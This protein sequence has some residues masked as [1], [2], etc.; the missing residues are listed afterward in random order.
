MSSL[1]LMYPTASSCKSATSH[2]AKRTQMITDGADSSI[3]IACVVLGLL[4]HVISVQGR[5][6][7]HIHFDCLT[8]GL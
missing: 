4:Q 2:W 1:P 5:Q 7:L 3:V 8:H 6:V